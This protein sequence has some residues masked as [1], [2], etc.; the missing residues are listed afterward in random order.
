MHSTYLMKWTKHLLSSNP[1]PSSFTKACST[2]SFQTVAVDEISKRVKGYL[3]PGQGL[4]KSLSVFGIPRVNWLTE[5]QT[6][7]PPGGRDLM[8]H[9]QPQQGKRGGSLSACK[10][11]HH[12]QPPLLDQPQ[13]ASGKVKRGGIYSSA[14]LRAHT[15][16]Q[17]LV[18]SLHHECS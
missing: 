17:H 12:E 2:N 14:P 7:K 15:R 13:S 3:S 16:L 4:R 1:F 18:Y 10:L 5:V 8:D 9:D 6:S 11:S